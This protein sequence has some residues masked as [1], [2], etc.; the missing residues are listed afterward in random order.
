[1][2]A[3]FKAHQ[4]LGLYLLQLFVVVEALRLIWARNR[5]PGQRPAEWLAS[6][7][8]GLV[9]LQVLLG[10]I[11]YVVG[12]RSAPMSHLALGIVAAVVL[13]VSKKMEGTSRIL[14]YLAGMV[15]VLG[16]V[17]LVL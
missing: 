6:A 14:T 7:V 8:I 12:P 2:H 16:T 1:M 10:L 9:D 4:G 5:A 11:L 13:H 15:C 3:L 17:Y